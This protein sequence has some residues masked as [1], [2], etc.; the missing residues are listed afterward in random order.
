ML[1]LF[2]Q[3]FV[4]IFIKVYLN[5][6]IL[7]TFKIWISFSFIEHTKSV[8][9]QNVQVALFNPKEVFW[10]TTAVIVDNNKCFSSTE[11]AY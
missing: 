2:S 11:S 4:M 10:S 6:L 8:I 1:F 3:Q 9:L 5:I 7:R